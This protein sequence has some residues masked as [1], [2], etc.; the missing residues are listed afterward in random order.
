M[1]NL[2]K[3]QDIGYVFP[4]INKELEHA[5]LVSELCGVSPPLIPSMAL[6]LNYL[7]PEVDGGVWLHVLR[8]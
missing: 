4:E 1:L 8:L 5:I 6:F 3:I 2:L 7:T